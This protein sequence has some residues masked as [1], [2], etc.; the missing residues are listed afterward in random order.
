VAEERLTVVLALQD[1]VPGLKAEVAHLR[2]QLDRAAAEA[3]DWKAR[4]E[5]AGDELAELRTSNSWKV[6]APLRAATT[7]VDR[8]TRPGR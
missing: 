7:A 2:G 6:T 1:A 8:W 4:A 3:A 5:R